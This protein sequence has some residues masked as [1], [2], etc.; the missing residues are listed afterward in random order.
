MSGLVCAQNFKCNIIYL[1]A[2]QK[3]M[4]IAERGPG[5]INKN[6]WNV[7]ADAKYTL[8]PLSHQL[9]CAWALVLPALS[10]PTMLCHLNSCWRILG[11]LANLRIR[12]I[13]KTICDIS[14]EP[15]LF[16]NCGPVLLSTPIYDHLRLSTSVRVYLHGDMRLSTR[17]KRLVRPIQTWID[18]DRRTWT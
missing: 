11:T 2:L 14:R 8:R 7:G 9:W 17:L 15:W 6:Y 10:T 4:S 13:I 18:T 16:S 3:F 12:Q 5:H 1:P